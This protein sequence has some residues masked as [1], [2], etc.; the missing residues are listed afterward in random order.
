[1]KRVQQRKCHYAARVSFKLLTL[2]FVHVSC[3]SQPRLVI[4]AEAVTVK[5]LSAGFLSEFPKG[6]TPASRQRRDLS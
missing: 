5:L 6:E 2:Q 3:L 1:M 4:A